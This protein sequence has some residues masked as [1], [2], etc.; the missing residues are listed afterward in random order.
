MKVAEFKDTDCRYNAASC[1]KLQV[2][3]IAASG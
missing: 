2:V 1:R 3:D